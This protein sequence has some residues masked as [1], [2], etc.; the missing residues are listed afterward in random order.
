L[1]DNLPKN[2]PEVRDGKRAWLP[3]IGTNQPKPGYVLKY[4]SQ[5]AY[6]AFLNQKYRLYLNR[7]AADKLAELY[8][9]TRQYCDIIQHL[10]LLDDSGNEIARD[11][12]TQK[13]LNINFFDEL[14]FLTALGS[15]DFTIRLHAS[16]LNL[17]DIQSFKNPEWWTPNWL[18]N[19]FE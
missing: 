7:F 12:I 9:I 4:L 16:A 2:L 13:P 3:G 1:I 15:H 10:Q 17:E 14:W 19:I 11:P 18:K 8:E 5:N 6:T